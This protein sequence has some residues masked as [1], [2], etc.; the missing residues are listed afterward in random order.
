MIAARGLRKTYRSTPVLEDVS[1]DLA[2]GE[3]LALLGANGAGKTTLLRILATL[4]RPSG[5]SLS[6][7]G[8]DALARPEAVRAAI[9]VVAHGSYVYEDLSAI[10]NLRFWI[11]LGGGDA[12]PARLHGALQ[13]VELDGVADERVRTFSAG[14]KRRLALAR[15][16]LGDARLL[17][18]D[19]PFTALD[20]RGRKWLGEFLLAF[21]ARGGAAVVATHSFASALAVAD[22]VAILAGGR[23][24]LDRPRAEL[25]WDALRQ[26][27]DS[28]TEGEEGDAL[29]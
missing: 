22:R 25:S 9:G 7:A 29:A 27:Y 18:L 13:Q 4:V 23:L 1:L 12:S 8:V 19:E 26:L 16:V 21:K 28:L 2:P 14:M 10:E 15:V 6:V 3:C 11:T 24:A 17:L 5:G 20:Q